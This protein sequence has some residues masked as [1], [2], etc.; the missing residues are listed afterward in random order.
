MVTLV[1]AQLR[2]TVSFA[3]AWTR[4]HAVRSVKSTIDGDSIE[5]ANPD[6]GEHEQLL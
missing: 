1:P 6:P 3:E 4:R 2:A 5:L